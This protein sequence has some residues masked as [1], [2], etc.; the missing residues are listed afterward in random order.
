MD[1]LK[2]TPKIDCCEH[3]RRQVVPR[4]DDSA[5]CP[6]CGRVMRPGEQGRLLDSDLAWVFRTYGRGRR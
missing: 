6:R 1:G 5:R 4:A 3:C 2:P